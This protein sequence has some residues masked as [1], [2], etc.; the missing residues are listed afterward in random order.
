MRE[1]K[2]THSFR[3]PTRVMP[4]T[5]FRTRAP[6]VENLAELC[7]SARRWRVRPS[8]VPVGYW[9]TNPSITMH[10]DRI[11]MTARCVNYH[12][13][14]SGYHR[15]DPESR[16]ILLLCELDRHGQIKSEHVMLDHDKSQRFPSDSIGYED[17]RLFSWKNQL[18]A[19]ATV[20]DRRPK[21]CPIALLTIDAQGDV[22]KAEIQPHYQ[23]IEKNWMPVIRNDELSWIYSVSP[24]L[25]T[26]PGGEDRISVGTFR[27]LS[28]Y[29]ISGG[30]Q[31]IACA[32]GYLAVC[33]EKVSSIYFHRFVH[34]RVDLTVSALSPPWQFSEPGI[35]FCAGLAQVHNLP[36]TLVLSWGRH[37]AECWLT[38][39][40]LEDV[41]QLFETSSDS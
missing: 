23:P 31:L 35:E 9:A 7:L 12:M 37:D 3:F 4:P 15:S 18:F 32:G 19:S 30:S 34:F 33:H 39:V 41:L 16:T 24:T 21:A 36:A 5:I 10:Q 29:P 6:K 40:L 17:A 2:K 26:Y 28:P 20:C 22:Q 14:G 11:W 1:E 8:K 13:V 27:P 38:E 25:V